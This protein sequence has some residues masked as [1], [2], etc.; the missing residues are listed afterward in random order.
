MSAHTVHEAIYI[1]NC[2]GASLKSASAVGKINYLLKKY[3]LAA[4]FKSGF[5]DAV[6]VF[7]LL[8]LNLFVAKYFIYQ[9]LNLWS[10]N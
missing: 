2:V 6:A 7:L 3:W 5:F 9:F 10:N 1:R 4:V 8:G